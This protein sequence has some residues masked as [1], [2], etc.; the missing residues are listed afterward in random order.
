VRLARTRERR[1]EQVL[2]P[3]VGLD[4]A[5]VA[6]AAASRWGLRVTLR[7][8]PIGAGSYHWLAT[9]AAGTRY[10]LTA[11]DL[12]DKPWLGTDP[13]QVF[14][15]LCA[16]FETALALRENARL[17]FV[18]APMPALGGAAAC[19]LTTRYSLAL[20]P[21]VNGRPGR[22]G[23]AITAHDA[24]ALAEVLARLHMATPV[25]ASRA[26]RR[27]LEL[28]GRA[29]LE[30][31]LCEL[32]RPWSAGPFA[33]RARRELAASSD[34]VVSWLGEF[35]ALAAR[36]ATDGAAATVTHG[37]PHPG[38]L[39]RTGGGLALIDWDT[40]A[41]ARP[42]RDLWMLA[43]AAP[44][45]LARYRQL[46][47]VTP[48]AGAISFYRLAWTL[49]DIAS[50]TADL[51]APHEWSR[52]SEKAWTS[53]RLSLEPDPAAKPGPYGRPDS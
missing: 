45:A 23:E 52:D 28:H 6:E 18:V 31:S 40:V 34:R 30:A 51:R 17:P 47:G 35:D 32:D 46:T 11:D 33:E 49:Y 15:G 7:F 16:A 14:A 43:D 26:L 48:D 36:L 19:R 8:T 13:D 50:Y 4:E 10:F 5:V 53:L 25:V 44:G 22:W 27:S 3:P 21:F 39:V 29:E 38:N 1:D 9:A 20:F 24:D 37:E 41:L 2:T 12:L 42:E